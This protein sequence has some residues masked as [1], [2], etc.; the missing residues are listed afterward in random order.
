MS[1]EGGNNEDESAKEKDS[2]APPGKKGK[3]KKNEPEPEPEVESKLVSNT[4]NPDTNILFQSEDQKPIVN[5]GG[6]PSGRL[7]HSLCLAR[8]KEIGTTANNPHNQTPRYESLL[9]LTGGYN[10]ENTF[11]EDGVWLFDTELRVWRQC[12][13]GKQLNSQEDKFPFPPLPR[14][15]HS[16]LGFPLTSSKV[17]IHGGVSGTTKQVSNRTF[18]FDTI[19]NAWDNVYPDEIEG[20]E[21]Q[22]LPP[23][24]CWPSLVVCKPSF[25]LFPKQ[26]TIPPWGKM[27]SVVL[28]I[29]GTNREGGIWALSG[30]Q[31]AWLKLGID[32][33]VFNDSVP[34]NPDIDSKYIV[35]PIQ[36][37]LFGET[38]GDTYQDLLWIFI[39]GGKHI[40][41]DLLTTDLL[42]RDLPPLTKPVRP[43]ILDMEYPNGDK[44]SGSWAI[45]DEEENQYEN[46]NENSDKQMKKPHGHGL[47][48]FGEN[49]PLGRI[50]YEGDFDK[51]SMKGY[52]RIKFKNGYTYIGDICNG[53][54][55]GKGMI[56]NP[57]LVPQEDDVIGEEEE[58]GPETNIIENSIGEPDVIENESIDPAFKINSYPIL[59]PKT[60]EKLLVKPSYHLRVAFPKKILPSS[61]PALEE[62]SELYEYDGDWKDGKKHGKGRVTYVNRSRYE[63]EW[64]E[65]KPHGRGQKYNL[66]KT[67]FWLGDFKEGQIVC[68]K[69]RKYKEGTN[70]QSTNM[71]FKSMTEEEEGTNEDL[72]EGE[73]GEEEFD[74]IAKQLE[75][76]YDGEFR[77]NGIRNGMGICKFQ[78]G[79]WYDGL[80]KNG[81]QNGNGVYFSNV[82]KATYYGKFVNGLCQ[83]KCRIK[84]SSG[85]KQKKTFEGFISKKGKLQ[86]PFEKKW[87]L[88]HD[89]I[90]VNMKRDNRNNTTVFKKHPLPYKS[91]FIPMPV[92][93]KYQGDFQK[94]APEV[95]TYLLDRHLN[96]RG[97]R[98]RLTYP[99]V[100]CY[101]EM[102]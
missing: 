87:E 16:S 30:N 101:T 8:G 34:Q 21:D 25:R 43:N 83:G 72:E 4:D 39:G 70:I 44:Y 37:G 9:A 55:H 74:I 71:V 2:K 57:S 19:L 68:G 11:L 40:A 63:G 13:R 33:G 41:G 54:P 91:R 102:S 76:E 82:L 60:H 35:S 28:A 94:P 26:P 95:L 56:F 46:P 62:T 51:G 73:Y 47:I 67:N 61:I 75:E 1:N 29:G 84:Y 42:C 97:Q 49:D 3:G 53:L 50:E 17:L 77:F 27:G 59:P 32:K 100:G 93:S 58:K 79:D 36:S 12:Q 88:E 14:K 98:K 24:S 64:F 6:W 78:N 52:G 38:N 45:F 85:D 80:W 22:R 89:N 20:E 92:K 96:S 90:V 7:G 15:Y 99:E 65:D 31:Q 86:E 48:K 23:P 81:K 5:Y 18:I 66:Q 10:D 69:E